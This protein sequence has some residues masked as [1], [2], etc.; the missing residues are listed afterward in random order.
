M[1]IA[2]IFSLGYGHDNSWDH[3]GYGGHEGHHGYGGYYR[4]DYK[5]H[6]GSYGRHHGGGLLGI[7]ISVL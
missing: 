2:E 1:K 7:R 5:H 3:K 6:R 4:S